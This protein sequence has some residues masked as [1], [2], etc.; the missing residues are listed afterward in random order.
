MFFF[1]SFLNLSARKPFYSCASARP[2]H[3]RRIRFFFAPRNGKRKG[4]RVSERLLR[5][6]GIK[7]ARREVFTAPLREA[8]ASDRVLSPSPVRPT[9]SLGRPPL[10]QGRDGVGSS[11]WH[12]LVGLGYLG[13]WVHP[14]EEGWK[15]DFGF[16]LLF[17]LPSF[18]VFLCYK[19]APAFPP[20]G[21]K[22]GLQQGGGEK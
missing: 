6:R 2:N 14:G 10:L 5:R 8:A 19:R 3:K 17:S 13:R 21:K 16:P 22:S 12:G 1:S 15:E 11:D 18:G 4:D 20:S 7:Q 9:R